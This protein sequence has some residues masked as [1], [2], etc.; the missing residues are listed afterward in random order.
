MLSLIIKLKF[1]NRLSYVNNFMPYDSRFS[2][3]LVVF[4]L[5]NFNLTKVMKYL[6]VIFIVIQHM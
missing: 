5:L 1:A 2:V 6:S 3:P 4:V